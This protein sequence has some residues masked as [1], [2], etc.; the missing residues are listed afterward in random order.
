MRAGALGTVLLTIRSTAPAGVLF[1]VRGT[2]SGN[3]F[4]GH[5]PVS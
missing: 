4:G 1:P 5:R 2:A 3:P